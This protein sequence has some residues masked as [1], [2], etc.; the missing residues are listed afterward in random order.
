MDRLPDEGPV[1]PPAP[2]R[3]TRPILDGISSPARD[4]SL[5][6]TSRRGL[7]SPSASS[8]G[9]YSVGGGTE[10]GTSAPL[11]RQ[12]APRRHPRSR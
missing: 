5:S 1:G 4:W 10:T 8:A 11:P 12:V 3:P 7:N 9:G 2:E 6:P